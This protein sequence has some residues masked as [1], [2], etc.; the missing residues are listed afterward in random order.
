MVM[1]PITG[2]IKLSMPKQN[3]VITRFKRRIKFSMP[4]Q[5]IMTTLITGKIKLTMPEKTG[6]S[7]RK[8]FVYQSV[9]VLRLSTQA[10]LSFKNVFVSIHN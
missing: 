9:T 2:R 4:K 8:K 1:T 3:I 10:I 7:S 6:N 5:N